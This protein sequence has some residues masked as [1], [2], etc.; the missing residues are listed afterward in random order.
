M[1]AVLRDIWQKTITERQRQGLIDLMIGH[2]NEVENLAAMK[3]RSI[4]GVEP[5]SSHCEPDDIAALAY[6][7]RIILELQKHGGHDDPAMT[8]IVRNDAD[9]MVWSIPFLPAYA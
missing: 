1:N 5:Q 2:A 9:Q 4:N 8:M 6:A 3:A 7:E